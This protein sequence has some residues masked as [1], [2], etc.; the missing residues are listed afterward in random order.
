MDTRPK[1]SS[2]GGGKS[3]EEIV[4]EKAKEYLSKLPSDFIDS[5]VRE[6]VSKLPGPK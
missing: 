1:D 3:R 6:Q 4:Y 2:V 5:E